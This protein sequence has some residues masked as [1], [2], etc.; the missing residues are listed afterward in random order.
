M[1]KCHKIYPKR[2]VYHNLLQFDM[3]G[4]GLVEKDENGQEIHHICELKVAVRCMTERLEIE[5]AAN[6]LHHIM[7]V[8]DNTNHLF[9]ILDDIEIVQ[10]RWLCDPTWRGSK[11]W[12]LFFN[13]RLNLLPSR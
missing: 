8:V 1:T 5:L 11:P 2:Y 6:N 12:T 9:T 7:R 4:N 10:R 13:S 3:L